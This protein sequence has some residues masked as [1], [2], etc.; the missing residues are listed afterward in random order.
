MNQNTASEAIPGI[1]ESPFGGLA[2]NIQVLRTSIINA[3]YDQ[4]CGMDVTGSFHGVEEIGLYRCEKTGYKFWRPETL[5]GDETFYKEISSAWPNYY[6]TGRWEHTFARRFLKGRKSIL[7]IGSGPGYFLKTLEAHLPNA[8]GIELN[9]EAIA[10]KVTRFPIR[11]TSM[12][13]LATEQ[14]HRFDAIYSFQV[15]EHVTNP[16]ILIQSAVKCLVPG[17]ILMFSTPNNDHRAFREQTDP[18]DLPPHHMGHFNPDIFK[19]I[20]D[21]FGL[22]VCRI[23]IQRDTFLTRSSID[24]PRKSFAYRFWTYVAK[25]FMSLPL[26][27]SG[28]VGPNI[29]VVYEKS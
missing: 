6:R 14:R 4:K 7:E 3:M 25:N 23:V 9:G 26:L 16:F 24:R 1:A 22:R 12:E 21:I 27:F 20:G 28:D 15:L 5:A 19:R 10:N 8:M 11:S 13:V 17:G 2:A 18:F 29:L